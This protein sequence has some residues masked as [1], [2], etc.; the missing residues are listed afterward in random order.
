MNVIRTARE[1]NGLS[2]RA[3]AKLV[4]ISP[5]YLS[6]L[7]T[8]KRMGSYKIRFK[9]GKALKCDVDWPRCSKCGQRMRE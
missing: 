2:L 1:K 5:S 9:I 3:L 6:D 8:S 4:G 7:E